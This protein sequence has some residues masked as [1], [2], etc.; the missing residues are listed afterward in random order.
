MAEATARGQPATL[1]DIAGE[2]TRQLLFRSAATQ[3][4]ARNLV[5][6]FLEER[7][8]GQMSRLSEGLK[9]T[10]GVQETGTSAIRAAQEAQKAANPFYE[11]AFSATEVPEQVAKVFANQ[12]KTAIGQRATNFM[13]RNVLGDMQADDINRM[14]AER[15]VALLDA[16]KRGLDEVIGTAKR[17]GQNAL[18]RSAQRMKQELL[19]GLDG[20]VPEYAK[21]RKIWS[22]E[23]A[24]TDAVDFGRSIFTQRQ[25]V[26]SEAFI[27]DFNKLTPG[28]KLGAM[29]GALDALIAKA[30]SVGEGTSI[31]EFLSKPGN[32]AKLMA[33]VPKSLRPEWRSL[34]NTEREMAR[35]VQ[36][37][38]RGSPTAARQVELGVHDGFLRAAK[39]LAGDIWQWVPFVGGRALEP[40][41]ERQALAAAQRVMSGDAA[42][43]PAMSRMGGGP[44]AQAATPA[45][46]VPL[47]G[48]VVEGQR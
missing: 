39:T 18:A 36:K 4:E 42:S 40:M 10:L 15:P 13:R 26:T 9:R 12:S 23:A 3:S 5:T 48:A 27:A 46:T 29:H 14:M 32:M 25:G 20:A 8:K 45:V 38:L 24:F 17:A 31:A 30:E 11:R 19:E 34:L 6:E 44:V 28:E 21:A 16:Y 33:V 37:V 43:I 47:A 2:N 35:T 1:A 22:D 41:R 7:A